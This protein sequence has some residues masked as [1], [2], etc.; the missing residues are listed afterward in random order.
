MLLGD[1]YILFHKFKEKTI[2]FLSHPA[3]ITD[4]KSSPRGCPQ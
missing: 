4:A 1:N 2:C 3:A